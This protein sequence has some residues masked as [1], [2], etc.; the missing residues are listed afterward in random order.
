MITAESHLPIDRT[1]LSK[2]LLGDV[3]KLAW[4]KP[5]FYKDGSVDIV[6]DS[7]KA[8]DFDAKTVSTESGKTIPYTK[9]VLSTGGT[10]RWLP[11]E[12]LKGDLSNV[13]VLR[14]VE[15][16]QGILKALGDNGKKVVV[17]GS[18]FIGM[19]VA[20]CIAGKKNAVSVIGMESEPMERVMGAEVG[21]IFRGLLEKNDV[22]FYMNASVD[23][24]NA[25]GGSKQVGAV[26]LK[27]GTSL[28]ADVVIE[29]VGIGPETSYL[30]GNSAVT[31]LKDGSLEVDE[32]F[33]VKGQPDVFAIGDI[34]TYPYKGPGGNGAPTRIEHWNVAQNSGRAVARHINSPSSKPKPFIPVFWSALGQQLRYAGNTVAGYDDVVLLGDTSPEKPSWVAYYTKG[35]E[36]VAVAS[37][38]KDPVMVQVA[39][40]MR[41]GRMISKSQIKDGKDPLQIDL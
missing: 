18:S 6:Y 9:L 40:L 34:A 41:A 22:K 2:A 38:G 21:K 32:F 31:L 1:K 29:G 10:A 7:V 11:L 19:E 4:R 26:L 23:K 13:F 39:E 27:D 12:G 5:Q 14:S 25:L 15:H 36:V 8:V 28:Q 3:D 17:I 20:N 33:N 35:D 37:M 16:V 24:A 30:K